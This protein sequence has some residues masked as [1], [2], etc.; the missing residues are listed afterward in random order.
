MAEMYRLIVPIYER[1]RNYEALSKCYKTLHLA[2]NKILDVNRTGKR[3]LGK[4]YR[5]VFFGQV[6]SASIFFLSLSSFIYH[7]RT[8][9]R[10]ALHQL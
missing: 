5:V 4:Y 8:L 2:Y 1:R 9:L 7:L 3:L 6:G 10:W